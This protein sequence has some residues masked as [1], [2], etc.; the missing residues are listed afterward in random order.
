MLLQQAF[1]KTQAFVALVEPKVLED[2]LDNTNPI[3]ANLQNSG[4]NLIMSI[5][6]AISLSTQRSTQSHKRVGPTVGDGGAAY[7]SFKLSYAHQDELV[8]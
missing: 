8:T 2:S 1:R 6:D 3:L 5:G 4:V 7:E